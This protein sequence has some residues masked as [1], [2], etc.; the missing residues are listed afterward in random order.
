MNNPKENI[1]S[2]QMIAFILSS[3]IGI[4]ILTLPAKL[5]EKTGHDGWLSVIISVSICSLIITI[6]ILLLRRYSDKSI[7]QINNI[8]YGK[9]LGTFFNL[10]II[11]YLIF[12][13][14]LIFRSLV[15]IVQIT[16][17]N[18][19]PAI[20]L[21]FIIIIPSIYLCIYG[22][23]PICRYSMIIYFVIAITILFFLFVA[24]N[25]KITFLMPLGE[26]G[27]YKIIDSVKLSTI[28]FIGFE[29]VSI[30]YPHITDKGKIL[31]KSLI[32]NFIT[33]LFY[34]L[35][36]L[37]TTALFGENF[38]KR[39]VYP[40]FSLS[41]TYN[42]PVFERLDLFY[43]SL[44]FPAMAGSTRMYLYSSNLAIRDLCK[45]QPKKKYIF[46]NVILIILL[47]RIPSNLLDVEKYSNFLS[48]IS[49]SIM[50][51]I[52]FSYIFSFINKRGVNKN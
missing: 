47:S 45:L 35:I 18:F 32:A 30:I 6:M 14:S 8:L 38:L 21:S 7:I 25:F 20:L 49:I 29:L 16:A 1:T 12:T 11:L 41:R 13:T 43:V 9:Y 50:V 52:V 34:I 46:L 27:L 37:S 26:S 40:L 5:A 15:N 3:Q 23:Q 36:V 28:S 10:Y 17:L 24:N 4:G 33:G 19:T 42:A 31:R 22:L 44:W 2:T 51:F 39:L 48:L